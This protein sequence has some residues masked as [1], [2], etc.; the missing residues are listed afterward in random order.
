[1]SLNANARSPQV[2]RY[3]AIAAAAEVVLGAEVR[4]SCR[5]RADCPVA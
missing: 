3:T 2:V 5:R 1:M 4:R